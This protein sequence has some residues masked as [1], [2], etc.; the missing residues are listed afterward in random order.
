[1]DEASDPRPEILVLSFRLSRGIEATGP[2]QSLINMARALPEYRFRVI[3]TAAEGDMLSFAKMDGSQRPVGMLL[4]GDDSRMIF[5]GTM[6]LGD[7]TSALEYG[8]DAERDMAG[9][10]ERVGPRRWRLVIPWPR[11]ESTL[12]VIELVPKG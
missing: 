5:L 7:E 4:R 11:W 6:M 10:M 12:D 9:A 8:R 1:M 3:G 2:N